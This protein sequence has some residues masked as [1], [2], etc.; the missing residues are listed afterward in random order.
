MNLEG[1]LL[2]RLQI[3]VSTILAIKE[4]EPLY[5]DSEDYGIY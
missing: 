1:N 3:D 4:D 2:V 5:N